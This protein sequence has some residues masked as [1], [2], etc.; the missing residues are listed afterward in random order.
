MAVAPL[1]R[2]SFGGRPRPDFT[3][4]RADAGFQIRFARTRVRAK[5]IA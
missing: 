2:V 4:P 1:V 3:R 5:R